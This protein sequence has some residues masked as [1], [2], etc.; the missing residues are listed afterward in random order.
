MGGRA[1]LSEH[2]EERLARLRTLEFRLQRLA[3]S[4]K[5]DLLL[6]Q[7]RARR[8]NLE[9]PAATLAA[10]SESPRRDDLARILELA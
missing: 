1:S 9:A 4:P 6:L 8:V 7:V 3:R 2:Y 10:W 5:R